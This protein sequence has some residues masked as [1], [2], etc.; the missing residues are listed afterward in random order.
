MRPGSRT[1]S[2]QDKKR[3]HGTGALLQLVEVEAPCGACS[4]ALFA[5]KKAQRF[6][7]ITT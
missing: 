2:Q 5:S 6:L 7:L 1:T 3:A 4:A